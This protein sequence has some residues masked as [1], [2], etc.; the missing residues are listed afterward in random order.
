[1]IREVFM[2]AKFNLTRKLNICNLQNGTQF[3]NLLK[4]S[5]NAA[6][7]TLQFNSNFTQDEEKRI[8]NALNESTNDQLLR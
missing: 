6:N 8:L 3:V 7:I 5:T 2:F 4:Y 1:M